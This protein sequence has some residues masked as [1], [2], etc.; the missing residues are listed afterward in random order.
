M[1]TLL[2]LDS[3]ID[4]V[5]SVSRELT[6]RFARAWAS[7]GSDRTVVVHDLV[8]D[9]VPHL[10]HESL[11][12][13]PSLRG[14]NA[15][16]LPREQSTQDAVIAELLSADVLV[17]GA[18][19]YNYSVPSTLKTWI[20]HVHVPGVLAP[21]G[22]DPVQPLKGRLAVIV[23]A[24]GGIY[25]EGTENEGRDHTVPPI[26]LILGDALGMRIDTVAV[27]RSLSRTLPGLAGERER[28]E[29]ELSA[30]R[31]RIDALAASA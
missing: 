1:P 13:A 11:H 15:P 17:I 14:A 8:A 26:D 30:A 6:A 22:A 10:A 19:M 5:T 4:P 24:R 27:S 12:W 28:F 21:F 16:E 2:Q 7:A 18:P 31:E 29:A 25:D 9:P 20:D 3:S 23:T